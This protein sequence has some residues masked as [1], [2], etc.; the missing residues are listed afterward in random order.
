MNGTEVVEI[1]EARLIA[2]TYRL[3]EIE[4]NQNLNLVD[5]LGAEI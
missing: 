5:Y 3:R 4:S 2:V 1:D